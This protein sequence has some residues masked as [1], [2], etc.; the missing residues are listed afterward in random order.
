MKRTITSRLRQK[1]TLQSEV[2]TADTAGGYVRA[3]EDVADVWAEI[4]PI[5]SREK[6]IAMQIESEITHRM[7]I[8]ARTGVEA[9][10]RLNGDGRIFYIRSVTPVERNSVLELLVEERAGV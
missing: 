8:R 3:W 5:S 9:S 6:L 7:T 4:T 10:Q 1:L 2:R